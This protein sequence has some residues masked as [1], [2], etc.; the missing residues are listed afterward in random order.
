MGQ[1]RRGCV[2]E[3]QALSRQGM[4]A[5]S[6]IG[7]PLPNRSAEPQH[8]MQCVLVSNAVVR[9]RAPVLELPAAEDQP[10]LVDRNAW[11]RGQLYKKS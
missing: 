5:C 2:V 11:L 9:Q 10:L 7:L 3:E 8:Q 6:G 4:G 1:Q